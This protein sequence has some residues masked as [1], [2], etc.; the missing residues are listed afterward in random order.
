M[1]ASSSRSLKGKSK[2]LIDKQG[3]EDANSQTPA[4]GAQQ[5]SVSKQTSRSL[6]SS[7][8]QLSS[9]S[10]QSSAAGASTE[11]EEDTSRTRA[12]RQRKS[13]DLLSNSLV[14]EKRALHSPDPALKEDEDGESQASLKLPKPGVTYKRF[15]KE[16]LE[17]QEQATEIPREGTLQDALEAF[18]ADSKIKDKALALYVSSEVPPSHA[19]LSLPVSE[20]VLH[21]VVLQKD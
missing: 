11:A 8:R 19:I 9:K 1:Q 3:S 5:K 18:R 12:K 10:K 20:Q 13:K 15:K 6:K 4:L 2:P 16:A 21:F 7:S 17:T 14:K